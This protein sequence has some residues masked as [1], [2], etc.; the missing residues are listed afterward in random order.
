MQRK[1]RIGIFTAELHRLKGYLEIPEMEI[2]HGKRMRE[3]VTALQSAIAEAELME[4]VASGGVEKIEINKFHT[5]LDHDDRSFNEAID[6]CNAHWA[7]KIRGI[8][9]VKAKLEEARILSC[10]EPMQLS[11]RI[12]LNGIIREVQVLTTHLL[13]KE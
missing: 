4:K 2:H 12:N 10:K 5:F 13:D 9:E 7:E 1:E 6:L 11:D 8:E 3:M